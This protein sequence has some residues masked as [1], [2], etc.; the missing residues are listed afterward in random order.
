MKTLYNQTMGKVAL[1]WLQ[2]G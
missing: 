1:P 2:S